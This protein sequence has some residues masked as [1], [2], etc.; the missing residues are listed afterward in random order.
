MKKILLTLTL[1][2]ALALSACSSGTQGSQ[3][4]DD[5]GEPSASVENET[6]ELVFGSLGSFY[7]SSWDPAVGWDGWAIESIGVG[8]TLFRLDENYQATPWLAVSATQ[9]DSRTWIVTLRDDV[10]FHNG[11]DMTAEAVKNCFERTMSA[12]DRWSEV[13]PFASLEAEGQTLTIQL[14]RPAP[15]L[16]NDLCDPL[17]LVYDAD[18]SEDYASETFDT[19]P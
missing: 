16:M 18:G 7:N 4:T 17:W 2:F 6:K 11:T 5:G 14:E 1:V 13:I 12:S 10:K 9:Q 8:E 15:N 3:S 19:G